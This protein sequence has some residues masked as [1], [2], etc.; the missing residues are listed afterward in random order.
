MTA[1]IPLPPTVD[2]D[3]ASELIMGAV[4]SFAEDEDWRES[5]LDEP[6]F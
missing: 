6:E 1:D 4:R 5:V 3:E 2:V